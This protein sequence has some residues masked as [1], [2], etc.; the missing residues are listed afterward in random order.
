MSRSCLH[1]KT[2]A[3]LCGITREI[4][5]DTGQVRTTVYLCMLAPYT[6]VRDTEVSRLL[7]TEKQEWQTP[8]P[9]YTSRVHSLLVD[10]TATLR[11]RNA[12]RQ[13]RETGELL[14]IVPIPAERK[15][16]ARQLLAAWHQKD[17]DRLAEELIDSIRQ[18]KLFSQKPETARR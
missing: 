17:G 1:W 5:I 13:L 6:G 4:N 11:Y 16:Y 7:K 14:A 15:M 12:I 9:W 8:D 10:G 18:R 2:A 3:K